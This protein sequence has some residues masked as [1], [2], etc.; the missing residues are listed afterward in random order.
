MLLLASCLKAWAETG[1]SCSAWGPSTSCLQCDPPREKR[2]PRQT[3]YW[4]STQNFQGYRQTLPDL[5]SRTRYIKTQPWGSQTGA[6]GWCRQKE[7]SMETMKVSHLMV[8]LH[9]VHGFP[10]RLSNKGPPLKPDTNFVSQESVGGRYVGMYKKVHVKQ[11]SRKTVQEFHLGKICTLQ[12]LFMLVTDILKPKL[13]LNKR[14]YSFCWFVSVYLRLGKHL[15]KFLTLV[16]IF[17][18]NLESRFS[19][20]ILSFSPHQV[21]GIY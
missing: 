19:L 17:F 2:H 20:A 18:C 9:Q 11:P 4:H 8:V 10:W 15:W 12:N 13:G 3:V 14:I 21:W 7:P 16:L 1:C 5:W 6:L